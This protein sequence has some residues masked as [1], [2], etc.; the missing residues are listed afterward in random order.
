MEDQGTP[1]N[2][3]GRNLLHSKEVEVT[4]SVVGVLSDVYLGKFPPQNLSQTVLGIS[5]LHLISAL[6]ARNN[7][8]NLKRREYVIRTAISRQLAGP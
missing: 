6:Y 8:S 2:E 1:E 4:V 5:T 3:W 7:M